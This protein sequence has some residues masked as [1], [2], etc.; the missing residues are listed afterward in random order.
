MSWEKLKQLPENG[1]ARVHGHPPELSGRYHPNGI[2]RIQIEKRT[3]V[4]KNINNQLV[5]A[6]HS[7]F[8]GQ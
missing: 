3:I 2:G 7:K 8:T 5:M 1:M 6:I 4:S